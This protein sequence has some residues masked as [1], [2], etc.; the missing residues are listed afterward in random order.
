[1]TRAV[2]TDCR[3]PSS[4]T[5]SALVRVAGSLVPDWIAVPSRHLRSTRWELV[6]GALTSYFSAR[7]ARLRLPRSVEDAH[8]GR[9]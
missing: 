1:M 4:V 6:E 3:L 2:H 5:Y 8:P 9:P 7:D